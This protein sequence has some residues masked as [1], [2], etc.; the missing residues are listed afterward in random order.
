MFAGVVS[1]APL[2]S[3]SVDTNANFNFACS[4]YEFPA[5]SQGDETFATSVKVN[6][7]DKV[8][9]KTSFTYTLQPGSMKANSGGHAGRSGVSWT[10]MKY[11]IDLPAGVTVTDYKL[12]AGTSS[13][14][15]GVAPSVIRIN[16]DGS[17]DATGTHLRISGNNE[18]AD[19][20]N[21]GGNGPSVSKNGAGGMEVTAGGSFTLPAVEVTVTAGAAGTTIKPAL[22]ISDGGASNSAKNPLTFLQREKDFVNIAYWERFNCNAAGAGAS[23]LKTIN[24]VALNQTSTT[25]AAPAVATTGVSVDLKATVA[26]AP[27]GGSVQFKDG[28]TNI[29]SAVTVTNGVATLP[30]TFNA[31]GAH[32]ITAVY[33]G[34][35]EFA[36]STSAPQT[37]N[38][39]IPAVTTGTTLN[40]P[41]NASTD[42][43]VDLT[44]YVSPTPTGGTVQFKDGTTLIGSPVNVTDGA[45]TLSYAFPSAGE[46]SVTA[47]FSGV[48]GFASSTSDAQ[49]VSVVKSLVNT[50]TTLTAPATAATGKAVDLTAAVTPADTGGTVQFKDGGIPIGG[51]VAVVGGGAT[52]SHTFEADGDHSITAMYSGNAD[53]ASSVSTASSVA[54]TDSTVS[55]ATTL[56]APATAATGTA[57]DLTATVAPTPEGGTVQF[58]DGATN[59]GG[60]IA[61]ANG[62]ATLSHAF[63]TNGVHSISAVYSGVAGFRSSIAAPKNITSSTAVVSSNTTLAAP[64][65]ATTG[66]AVDLTAAVAPASTGGT[67]QFKDGDAYIGAPVNVVNGSATLKYTFSTAGTH[68]VTAV[69]SGA[70]NVSGSTSTAQSVNVS[71]ADFGTVTL[72]SV[73]GE[74]KTGVATDLWAS[75][76]TTAGDAVTGVG[77]VQFFDGGVA[78]G[79]PEAVTNGSAGRSH[80]FSTAGT[81]NITAKYTGGAGY[82]DSSAQA[83][84][85]NVTVPASTDIATATGLSAPG[86]VTINQSVV[87]S[88]SVTA[89]SNGGTVQF[90]DGD[91]PLG[92]GVAVVNGTATLNHTFASS[93]IHSVTAVFSGAEG[94]KASTSDVRI[95]QVNDAPTDNGGTGGTGSL[96][97]LPFG[98]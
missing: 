66:G 27:N 62:K 15:S 71:V 81:H 94:F 51:P 11:D 48:S 54:V 79:D 49:S 26:P 44:A 59:I 34:V 29:G 9:E 46:H 42:N 64:A 36:G 32:A 40:V 25:V 35:L 72:L 90:M 10:R 68:N 3:P 57:V 60:E 98:S 24:V 12:V 89:V 78:I 41:A 91:A 45:A 50:T 4:V 88:A 80:T 65:T 6:A 70:A 1:A 82:V 69:Y 92:E 84:S 55:T 96:G 37:V 75:V 7:P 93:G 95:V 8:V 21:G 52:L 97:G 76:R 63:T 33:D 14:L 2:T 5:I 28:G 23:A 18:T 38:V 17:P 16:N 22:R 61:V 77:T 85:V 43:A 30:H 67:V 39:D 31:V 74:A 73:P 58:K 53:F 83:R 47:I 86:S 19:S 87:L 56:V 20:N 13:G